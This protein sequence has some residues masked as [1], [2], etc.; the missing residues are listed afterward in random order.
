MAMSQRAA[1]SVHAQKRGIE[2]ARAQALQNRADDFREK[3]PERAPEA[4]ETAL[5]LRRSDAL[6]SVDMK[7]S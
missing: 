5:S 7:T 4:P 1:S 6:T 2:P 3:P